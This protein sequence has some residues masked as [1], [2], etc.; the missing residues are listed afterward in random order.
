[1]ELKV[2]FRFDA[3]ESLLVCVEKLKDAI[4]AMSNTGMLDQLPKSEREITSVGHLF[5]PEEAPEAAPIAQ[6][7]EPEPEPEPAA[8]HKEFTEVDVRE[9]ME[10]ARRR[11]EGEDYE[12]KTSEGRKA[13]HKMLTNQFKNIA[14]F[15][16]ADRP[17][18]LPA[19]KRGE[20]ISQCEKIEIMSDGTLGTPVPF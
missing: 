17:S 14:V 18:E 19:E 1:M 8:D 12:N 6:V 2:T 16:G 3:S 15:L 4:V 9:A 13:Y 20:F 11:I 5:L 10:V 7:V